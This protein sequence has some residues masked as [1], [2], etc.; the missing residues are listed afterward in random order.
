MPYAPVNNAQIYYETAGDEHPQTV[1][2]AH[3]GIADSRMWQHQVAPFAEKYRVVT[4]DTRGYGKSA[5]VEGEFS[6][7]D[8]LAGLL[9][10]LSVQQA[11]L[12]GCSMNGMVCMDFTLRWPERVRALVMVASRPYGSG[13][14]D[15]ETVALIKAANAA[16]GDEDNPDLDK[17]N[18]G[19]I[20]A[21][22]V[23][24][25]RTRDQLDPAV[26]QLALE[27]NRQA[28]A[29][30]VMELG[31]PTPPYF[32][33]AADRLN[34]ITTPVLIV[35]GDHDRAYV[36][37]AADRMAAEIPNARKVLLNGTAHLPNLE[38]PADFNQLVLDFLRDG[39]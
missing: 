8:D 13:S 3:A 31:T 35:Y 15:D 26:L 9:D 29:F 23:G 32:T 39:Q 33:D 16:G 17:I 30:E 1:V 28:L 12:V 34:Q 4:F 24:V 5:P 19:E 18:A 38:R 10:H 11:V 36:T 27:M 21:W 25:G 14:M 37:A 20:D 22:V 7:T 6:L 2:F